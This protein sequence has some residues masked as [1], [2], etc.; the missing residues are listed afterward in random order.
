MNFTQ[1]VDKAKTLLSSGSA[2]EAEAV[3]R[4]IAKAYA[5][6]PAEKKKEAFSE[7]SEIQKQ[8]ALKKR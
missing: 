1:L 8:L 4:E 5:G 3:Y 7:C 2:A 6:L